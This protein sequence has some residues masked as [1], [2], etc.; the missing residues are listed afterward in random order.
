M[1]EYNHDGDAVMVARGD[2]SVNDL[3]HA[4]L[5]DEENKEV[6]A[7]CHYLLIQSQF[8]RV[9]HCKCFCRF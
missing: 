4:S 8:G 2:V 5:L 3:L 7:T 6:K 1:S 9:C